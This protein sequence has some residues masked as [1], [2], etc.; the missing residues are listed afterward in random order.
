MTVVPGRQVVPSDADK[1][2][3]ELRTQV[4]WLWRFAIWQTL[5]SLLLLVLWVSS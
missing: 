4:M 2:V 3:D 1:A 5:F